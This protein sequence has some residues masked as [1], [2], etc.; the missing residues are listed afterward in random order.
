M[1]MIWIARRRHPPWLLAFVICLSK[2]VEFSVLKLVDGKP[3]FLVLKAEKVAELLKEVCYT[4]GEILLYNHLLVS[5]V[6]SIPFSI[7]QW[8]VC[9][10][11]CLVHVMVWLMVMVGC[12][13]CNRASE[14]RKKKKQQR[15]QKRKHDHASD[16]WL[17]TMI[18]KLGRRLMTSRIPRKHDNYD[19]YTIW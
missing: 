8:H 13:M 7:I 14:S 3:T 1:H 2:I 9:Y 5:C 6:L 11:G 17:Q 10:E 4:H 12:P 15:K 19:N 18:L 16:V